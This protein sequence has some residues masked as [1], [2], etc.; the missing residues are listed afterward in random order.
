MCQ[1]RTWPIYGQSFYPVG[2]SP[3][4]PHLGARLPMSWVA[5]SL[6][7]L[8]AISA[9]AAYCWRRWPF[10]PVGWLWFLGM[11][12]PVIG[13]VTVGAH[14][15][16]RADRYMY[17]PQI[18]L[19]IALA[20]GAWSVYRSRQAIGASR[21]RG[22][23]LATVSG[24]SV[25][26]LTAIAWRQTSYWRDAETLW[27]HAI[28]CDNHNLI[29]HSNL[30]LAYLKQERFDEAIEQL[31]FTTTDDLVEPEIIAMYHMLLA[32]LLMDY[33]SIDEAIA[34]YEQT[35][36]LFP[37]GEMG[38]THLAIALADAGR[39]HEAI[40]EWRESIRLSPSLWSARIGMAKDLL[41][42]GDSGEA[43]KECREVLKQ[44]PGAVEAIVILGK[45]LAAGGKAEQAIP[46]FE[47][48]LELSPANAQAHFQL[49]L[50]LCEVG[51]SAS[52]SRSSQRGGS[53]SA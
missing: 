18:G 12:V 39:H 3:F 28:A 37:A 15:H 5:G 22:W 6:V 20:W 45:A 36:H 4:Y 29:A 30:A 27:S 41:A 14:G 33:G 19:S 24:A 13:L 40:A 7:L 32:D 42:I 23:M 1:C 2:M 51:R 48:A 21:W 44:E 46:R 10:V 8:A 50:A 49:G 43:A 16:A 52:A 25:L 9:L 38:H 17:L 47:Q 34:H 11:L 26:A 35:V 53:A 31:R